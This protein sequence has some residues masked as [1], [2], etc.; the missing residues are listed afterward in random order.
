MYTYLKT[1]LFDSYITTPYTY[2]H[3]FYNLIEEDL[4]FCFTYNQKL[5]IRT[6][7]ARLTFFVKTTIDHGFEIKSIYYYLELGIF[8]SHEFSTAGINLHSSTIIYNYPYKL[9]Y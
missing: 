6:K 7:K 3:F 5:K 1:I 4:L 8:D 9:C 2:E